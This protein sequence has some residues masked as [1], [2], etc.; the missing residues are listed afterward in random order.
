MYTMKG[1]LYKLFQLIVASSDRALLSGSVFR[2]RVAD[3]L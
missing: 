2:V 3:V 1:L